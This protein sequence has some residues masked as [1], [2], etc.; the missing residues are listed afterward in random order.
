MKSDNIQHTM[1]RS[2]KVHFSKIQQF[3]HDRISHNET[4]NG[5]Y[6]KS[7]QDNLFPQHLIALYNDSSI[8]ASAVN[9]TV[10]AIVGGG[11]TANFEPALE[12]ANSKGDTWNDVFTKVSLDYYLHGSF[13]LEVIWSL[14]RTK[15]AEV[16]HIDFSFVR[17]HERDNKGIIPGYYISSKWDQYG[18]TR[19]KD[20]DYLPTYDPLSKQEEPNQLFVVRNYRPGQE[21]YPLP[22]YNGALRVIELD[23]AVDDFHKNNI[24]NGLAPSVAI[25]TFTNGSDDDIR[26][27][28]KNLRANYG[29]TTNAGAMIYMDVDQP[30]NAPK[31]EPIPQ[32]G[33][34]GYY[35]TINDVTTQKILTGHRITSPMMLGIKTESQLGGRDEVVDAFLLW[36]NTVI[37]PL[38]QDIL[39]QL[40]ILIDVNYDNLTIGVK[41][42]KLYDD[43]E[44]VEDIVTSVETS[45]DEDRLINE[46]LDNE[47]TLKS[48]ENFVS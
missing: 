35:T 16:H 20:V 28:E 30:E 6:V 21:Y 47:E 38:Q 14:D 12:R 5:K 31:I 9:A 4:V 43:G 46:Q 45:D 7:G 41:R 26:D 37:E 27:I 11:L 22:T 32:N 29:G 13:A 48:E 36:F 18:S 8:H 44:E 40:E 2:K 39:R 25:T 19:A 24:E 42:K 15:I 23:A 17:A 33:A 34:D 10:E 3:S 1:D